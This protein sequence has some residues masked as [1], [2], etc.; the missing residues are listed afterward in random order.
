ID[1]SGMEGR[2][3][4]EDF[5][6]INKELKKYNEELSKRPQIVAANKIDIADK[7]GVDNVISQLEDLSYKVFPISAATGAGIKELMNHAYEL[8]KKLPEPVVYD[9]EISEVIYKVEDEEPFT[10]EIEDDVFV[11]RGPWLD[12]LLRGINFTDRESLQYFQRALR[13]K[14]VIEALEEM[15]ITDGDTVC[16]GDDMEFE[17]TP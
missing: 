8:V 9:S 17:Y 1:V 5:H 16:I 6:I 2:D 7:K 13:R 11:V 15:G 3:P 14:G 12:N 10:I 4:I